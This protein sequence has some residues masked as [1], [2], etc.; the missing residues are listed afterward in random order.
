MSD[1]FVVRLTANIAA[2]ADHQLREIAACALPLLGT[3]HAHPYAE[4]L[5]VLLMTELRVRHE[6]KVA[7]NL[8]RILS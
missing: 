6:Q 4:K 2:C 5:L 8:E 7:F 3:A 1:E